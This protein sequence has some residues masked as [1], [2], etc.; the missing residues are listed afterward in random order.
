VDRS[1]TIDKMIQFVGVIKDVDTTNIP[2]YQVEATPKT[3]GG[4][5][6][7]IWRKDSQNMQAILDI[8]RGVAPLA[9]APN[10]KFEDTTTTSTLPHTTTSATA[11]ESTPATTATTA[12]APG[13]TL[14]V[15]GD[16]AP[17]SNA[18]PSAIVPDAKATC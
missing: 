6:V 13:G 16:T 7:L 1:L 14:P 3:V 12:A 17:L 11:A 18:P 9:E 2:T 5:A 4:N 10:Q 8:F 15:T